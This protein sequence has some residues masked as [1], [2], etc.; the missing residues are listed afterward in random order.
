MLLP[1]PQAKG[2]LESLLL[3]AARDHSALAHIMACSE[4]AISESRI[5]AKRGRDKWNT[6]Q[7]DKASLRIALALA[8]K[9]N[10]MLGLG[11][12]WLRA[13]TLIPLKSQAFDQLA[14]AITSLR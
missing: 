5:R 3:S 2:A 14:K 4:N 6:A 12:L 10:P 1:A 8:H 11:Q 7:I 13:P 9:K